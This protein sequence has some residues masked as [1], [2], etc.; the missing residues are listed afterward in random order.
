MFGLVVIEVMT[1]SGHL[2]NINAIVLNSMPLRHIK[3]GFSD[4]KGYTLRNHINRI[5]ST[6]K[7]RKLFMMSFL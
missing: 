3:H 4:L 1:P 5:S 2:S 7:V 6:A